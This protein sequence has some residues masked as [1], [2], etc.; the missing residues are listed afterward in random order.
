MVDGLTSGSHGDSPEGRVSAE[1]A[2]GL[3]GRGLLVQWPAVHDDLV[4]DPGYGPSRRPLVLVAPPR[5]SGRD[6]SE[7]GEW[8]RFPIPGN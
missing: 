6:Q 2:L 5:S 7:F 1:V 3:M 8:T 4:A